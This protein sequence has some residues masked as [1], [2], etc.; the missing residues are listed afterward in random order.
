MSLLHSTVFH[1]VCRTTHHRI[2]VD[3]LRHLRVPD[4]EK[5]TDLFLAN[6]KELLA[7]SEAPDERFQ[8]FKNHVVH[9][10]DNHWGGAPAEAARWYGRLVDAM[11]RRDWP[12]DAGG[13]K[14]ACMEISAG[15]NAQ[16]RRHLVAGHDRG[17]DRVERRVSPFGR[18]ER[19]VTAGLDEGA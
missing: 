2:V 17:Q 9:V 6:Y 15:H 11:R 14:A 13:M 10:S 18:S 3:A 19:V 1:S 12:D 8:D 7:G 16:P 4:A 5:W